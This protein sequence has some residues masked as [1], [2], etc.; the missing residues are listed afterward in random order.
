MIC[1]VTGR[2]STLFSSADLVF[3]M[4]DSLSAGFST[5]PLVSANGSVSP[6]VQVGK[7]DTFFGVVHEAR[8]K[9]MQPVPSSVLMFI[10]TLIIY[11]SG[12]KVLI[13]PQIP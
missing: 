1:E 10:S 8:S 11:K 4:I 2:F 9:A 5:M 7:Y 12:A 6:S 13:L 3:T